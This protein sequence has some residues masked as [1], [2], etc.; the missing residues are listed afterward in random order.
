MWGAGRWR[1]SDR[2]QAREL[3]V[4]TAW[5]S[6][7]ALPRDPAREAGPGQFCGTQT[8]SWDSVLASR[9]LPKAQGVE[10]FKV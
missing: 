10:L 1:V 7:P 3:S 6:C 4:L 8:Q 9:A 2:W 5:A